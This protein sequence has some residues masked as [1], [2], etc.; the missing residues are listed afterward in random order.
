M[1]FVDSIDNLNLETYC[2]NC[3]KLIDR[4]EA[5]FINS[6]PF[7]K[8]CRSEL[9]RCSRCRDLHKIDEMESLNGNLYCQECWELEFR[10]NIV[11]E[12]DWNPD[13]F[14]PIEGDAKI[15]SEIEIETPRGRDKRD[16]AIDLYKWLKKK[17]IHNLFYFK[18]DGSL[19]NGFEI[20]SM[21]I[22]FS[23]WESLPL[24]EFFDYIVSIG[25]KSHDTDTCGLHM[26]IDREYIPKK[27]TIRKCLYFLSKNKPQIM[28]FT[29]RNRR[30]M[31]QYATISAW[32]LGD[33]NRQRPIDMG[34]KYTAINVQHRFSYEFRIYRGTLKYLSYMSCLEFTKLL[35]DF[36]RNY[37]AEDMK[38]DDFIMY[39]QNHSKYLFNYLESR[40]LLKE[41]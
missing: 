35:P 8:K 14:S 38:W 15:G 2:N 13:N 9:R 12:Y 22:A 4:R 3:D 25:G 36:A 24:K 10:E 31:D 18:Y 29:R 1:S 39:N 27:D 7:C 26:H 19:N 6:V 33:V 17:D 20:V 34:S 16:T 40:D 21:P 30:R 11:K 37:P 32:S 41:V 5:I 28:K 23:A